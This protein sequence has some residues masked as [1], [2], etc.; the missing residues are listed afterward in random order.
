MNATLEVDTC[1]RKSLQKLSYWKIFLAI[2]GSVLNCPNPK[3]KLKTNLW[4]NG[5]A[6]A[7]LRVL[8]QT[9]TNRRSYE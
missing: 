2:E 8:I 6:L 9:K 5:T 3:N 7:S 1:G 4:R